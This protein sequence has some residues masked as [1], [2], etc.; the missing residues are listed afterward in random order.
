MPRNT[1]QIPLLDL[2][3]QYAGVRHEVLAEVIRVIY[4]HRLILGE[5]V[6]ALECAIAEYTRTRFAIGWR[7]N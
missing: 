4:S 1:R 6:A 2:R 3:A 5:D 7:R